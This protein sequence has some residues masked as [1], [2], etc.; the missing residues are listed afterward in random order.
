MLMDS[1]IASQERRGGMSE[2][3]TVGGKQVDRFNVSQTFL[4]EAYI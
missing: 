2:S 4:L 1:I 3:L